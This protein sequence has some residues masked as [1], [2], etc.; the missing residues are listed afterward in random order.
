M[1]DFGGRSGA[2]WRTHF[3][4]LCRGVE[5]VGVLHGVTVCFAFQAHLVRLCTVKVPPVRCD[6]VRWMTGVITPQQVLEGCQTRTDKCNLQLTPWKTVWLKNLVA[7]VL[8]LPVVPVL[9]Q[10]VP[11]HTLPLY[12]FVIHF[13]IILL[14]A[15][16]FLKNYRTLRFSSRFFYVC[17]SVCVLLAQSPRFP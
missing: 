13:N 10:I 2:D 4:E 8:S 9:C 6:V 7:T 12:L 3:A 1:C 16:K 14:P 5:E 15:F 11:V 17:L